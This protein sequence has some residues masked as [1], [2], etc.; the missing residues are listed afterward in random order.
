M[1][2]RKTFYRQKIAE[3]SCV[4]KETVDIDCLVT[5]RNGDRKIMQSIRI[6]VRP[7][8]RIRKYNQLNHFERNTYQTSK[9]DLSWLHFDDEPRVQGKQ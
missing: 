3:F 8:S 2:Q 6:T 1:G 7:P 5:S 9:E 4:R